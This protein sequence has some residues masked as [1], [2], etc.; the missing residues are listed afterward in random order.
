[1]SRPHGA[2]LGGNR[3]LAGPTRSGE[4]G[5]QG[6]LCP[7]Y[8]SDTMVTRARGMANRGRARPAETLLPLPSRLMATAVAARPAATVCDSVALVMVSC[9][10]TMTDEPGRIEAATAAWEPI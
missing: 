7:Y 3:R 9:P 1:M 10:G 2:G 5:T 8:R 4:T 6:V